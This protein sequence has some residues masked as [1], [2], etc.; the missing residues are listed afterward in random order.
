MI[1]WQL[2]VLDEAQNIKNPYSART[3]ACKGLKRQ[4]S[5]AVSGTPFENH[6]SDI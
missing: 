6:I 5:L 4:R 1:N 2:V 3:K